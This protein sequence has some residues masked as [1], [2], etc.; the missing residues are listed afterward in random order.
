MK[1]V[2]LI[3][4]LLMM[5]LCDSNGADEPDVGS[6]NYMLPHCRH[7]TLGGNNYD[8]WDGSCTGTLETLIFLG[9]S[10]SG[11]YKICAPKQATRLQSAQIVVLYMQK[12]PQDLHRPFVWLAVRAL[13]EGWP[14]P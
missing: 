11:E 13:S 5:G 6:G 10:L 3:A 9:A 12:H 1:K 14:C 4:V 2:A 7:V 8:P